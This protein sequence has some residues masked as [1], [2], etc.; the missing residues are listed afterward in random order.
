ML[1][2]FCS[3]SIF[4]WALLAILFVVFL[5]Q[6]YYYLW[7]FTGVLLK[8]KNHNNQP[9]TASFPP[10]SVVIC[11]RNEEENLRKFLPKIMEQDYPKFEV[12]LVDD[13]S[14][15]NTDI[16]LNRFKE[17]YQNL[18]VT[19][20]PDKII[21]ASRK[22]LALT[23]GIKAAKNEVLLMTDADCYPTSNQWIKEMVSLLE[24]KD[25]VLGYGDYECHKSFIS[26][27]INYD[28]L[29]IAMQYFGFA[30][31]GK[32][33]MAI[34]RNLMYR[35]SVFFE[36][37]GFAGHLHI[38]SG[39]DDLMVNKAANSKNTA[40]ACSC[41]SKTMS[42]PEP[43]FSKWIAQKSRHLKASTLYTFSSRMRIGGEVFSRGLFYAL[44][45]L[46]AIFG[47]SFLIFAASLMFLLRYIVQL[48]VINNTSKSLES[49][50]FFLFLI[51]ADILLP[52]ISLWLIAKNKW[53][54]K[55]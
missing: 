37:N 47:N 44:C 32:P 21:V 23:V 7:Y 30:Y 45:V 39:D 14:E 43:T 31:R 9:E 12:V 34:G 18:Y 24:D 51:F 36:N 15:D 33:Y 55:R 38:P 35:K 26:R 29:F 28:T 20:I 8:Q 52:I 11:A 48:I 27:L 54:R 5:V 40:I 41:R 42:I 50:S 49:R 2:S 19:R 25:F 16:L 4:Q 6:I 10:V 46:S 3:F 53:S 22:K 17:Q 1:W 13:A